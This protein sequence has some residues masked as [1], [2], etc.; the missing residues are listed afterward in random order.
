MST[1]SII[2][3]GFQV[4]PSQWVISI[5]RQ[6]K[7]DGVNSEH[8]FLVLEGV[9]DAERYIIM[10]FD[11]AKYIYDQNKPF[12]QDREKNGYS[13]IRIRESGGE[14]L[15]DL[16]LYDNLIF[17]SDQERIQGLYAKSWNISRD[18]A[19]EL[20]QNV[21]RDQETKI[22]YNISGD[23]SM[24]GSISQA[25]SLKRGH[26]CFTWSREKLRQLKDERITIDNTS[27]LSDGFVSI[28][29]HHIGPKSQ[30]MMC[31]IL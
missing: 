6:P 22:F 10:R 26:N 28:T 3:Q 23:E 29:S 12:R 9:N 14:E 19:Q 30:R 21:K 24:S 17:E 31:N 8:A 13:D 5:V 16:R 25:S 20:I 27:K 11:L 7:G 4:H 18:Q 15:Q 2:N 1:R